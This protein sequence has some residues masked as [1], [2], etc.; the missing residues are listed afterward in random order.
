MTVVSTPSGGHTPPS[1]P[2]PAPPEA[3]A[4]AAAPPGLIGESGQP[5]RALAFAGGAFDTAL[6]L[7]A[8]HALL[9]SQAKAP[10]VVV[11]VSAG[12]VNAV[13]LAEVMQAGQEFTRAKELS[14]QE[15][16]RRRTQARVTRFREILDAFRR[17]PG[18][19]L[20]S[21]KPDTFQIDAQRPLKPLE[22]PT[23]AEEERRGRQAALRSRSGLINLYNEILRLRLSIGTLTRAVRR[24]LGVSAAV[25]IRSPLRR[26]LVVTSELSRT[27]SLAGLNLHHLAPLVWPLL[28]PVVRAPAPESE[29]GSAGDLI[30]HSRFWERVMW[31]ARYGGS[32]VALVLLWLGVTVTIGLLPVALLWLGWLVLE[33]AWPGLE[34]GAGFSWLWASVTLYGAL[35]LG[36]LAIVRPGWRVAR[37]AVLQFLNLA[38]LTACGLVAVWLVLGAGYLGSGSLTWPPNA[39]WWTDAV[40]R[41]G[42]WLLGACSRSADSGYWPRSPRGG[43]SAADST[44]A[45]CCRATTSPKACS[46]RTRSGSSS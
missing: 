25:E 29:G 42:P 30:F 3:P 8:I 14:E 33:L 40:A 4:N 39:T 32:L 2:G 41:T 45:A 22:L 31:R 43:S 37:M 35:L 21:L 27:W 28:R 34:A 15:R 5:V 17:A 26:A 9:V 6:Q 11:G 13:A 18:E 10:D 36:G 16:R 24:V 44:C 7:G 46:P 23:H 19:I 12:A 38:L 1:P 20:D